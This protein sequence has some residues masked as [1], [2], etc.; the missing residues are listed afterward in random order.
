MQT[1]ERVMEVAPHPNKQKGQHTYFNP[2][3]WLQLSS[4][5]VKELFSSFVWFLCWVSLRLNQCF[6]DRLGSLVLADSLLILAGNHTDGVGSSFLL[7]FCLCFRDWV[8][9]IV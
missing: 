1:S 3:L 5:W 4:D 9:L 8:R 2:V 6:H 7:S